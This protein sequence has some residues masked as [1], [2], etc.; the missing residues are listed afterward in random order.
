[1]GRRAVDVDDL[2]P[3]GSKG[4]A[5]TVEATNVSR[6][7]RHVASRPAHDQPLSLAW[8][9]DRAADPTNRGFASA[10]RIDLAVVGAGFAGQW[11]EQ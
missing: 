11:T 10:R 3:I 6:G 5:G 1:M 4:F 2:V 8:E 9:W 7:H